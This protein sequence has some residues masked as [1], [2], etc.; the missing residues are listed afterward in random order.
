M[1]IRPCRPA[2]TPFRSTVPLVVVL[3]SVAA[4][5]AIGCSQPDAE[6]TASADAAKSTRAA[7]ETPAIPEVAEESA[8]DA[9]T[10]AN[11]L[12]SE[13]YWPDIV[14]LVEPWSPEGD[15]P[16]LKRGLR[17][18]LIRVEDDLRVRIAFGR[19]GNH[20]LPLEKTDLLAR[21]EEIRSGLR[22]KLGPNFIVHFGTQ[23]VDPERKELGPYSTLRLRDYG[24]FLCV[25]AD[26]RSPDF[27]KSIAT[28]EPLEPSEEIRTLFFPLGVAA[29]ELGAVREAL[30]AAGWLVPFAYPGGADIQARSILGE[31]SEAPIALLLTAEG[32]VLLRTALDSPDRAEQIRAAAARAAGPSTGP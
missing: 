26:P 5:W 27:K 25:F 1:T 17:G 13:R 16:P 24:L 2:K 18:A 28:L 8:S 14:A 29:G 20:T 21:A 7:P 10:K 30:A 4:A 11:L 23:F 15:A 12:A 6:P 31:P 22:H 9:I 32:R 3:I 19:H